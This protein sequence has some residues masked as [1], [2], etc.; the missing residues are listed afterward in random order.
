MKIMSFGTV[1]S[2]FTL[3]QEKSSGL[4]PDDPV[5]SSLVGETVTH[6]NALAT[7]TRNCVIIRDTLRGTLII[8]AIHR[9]TGLRKSYATVP[10]LLVVSIALFVIAAA[11]WASKQ[12]RETVGP[13]AALGLLFLLIFLSSSRAA[14]VFLMDKEIVE[15]VKGS[16]NEATAVIRA[17]EH[18]RA[19]AKR[20]R[21]ADI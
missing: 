10:V 19:A 4:K 3:V 16:Y 21:S 13:I 7:V 1:G 20:A 17:V 12:G 5:L 9:L 14:V 15:S 11:A 18:V 8:V 6:A 2:P